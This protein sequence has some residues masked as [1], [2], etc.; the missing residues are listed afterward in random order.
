[1]DLYSIEVKAEAVYV[2]EQSAPAQN[3]YV[4]AYT[5]TLRNTG[6]VPARLLNRHWR[7]TDAD[8]KVQE[9]RGEGV[10]GEQPY[11]RPG[12]QYR[13][14]S[15]AMLPTPLGT[16]QGSYQMLANDGEHFDAPIAP[17]R[18]SQPHLLH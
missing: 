14:S 15:A 2:A 5:I 8:G 6:Q 4:F 18:L 9:V 1:M 12:E 13:Y 16:M 11:L 3:R 7:I 10:V 17:F